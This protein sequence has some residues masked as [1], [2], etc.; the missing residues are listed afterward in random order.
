[1]LQDAA[2]DD[3]GVVLLRTICC[4]GGYFRYGDN[5]LGTRH[6]RSGGMSC[7]LTQNETFYSQ[8]N[9]DAK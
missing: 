8:K 1:M 4:D 6:H 5:S 2:V 7:Y 3:D 9:C